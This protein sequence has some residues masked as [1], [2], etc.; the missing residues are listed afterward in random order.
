[1]SHLGGSMSSNSRNSRSS[2]LFTC[3]SGAAVLALRTD[4]Q[5]TPSGQELRGENQ[6]S[7]EA[8]PFTEY[9][10][11]GP[12]LKLK[13]QYFVH[14]MRWANSLEKTLMLGRIEGSRGR[15][16][17]RMRW[18]DGIVDSVGMSL[19][20]LRETVKARGSWRA[21]VRGVRKSQTQASNWTTEMQNL[22]PYPGRSASESA[23]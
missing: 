17:Q 10:L 16:W 14:L 5:S 18:P 6:I 15:G 9:S 2:S 4:T 19:S 11:E 3:F 21:A 20:K 8:S 12:M 23:C 7:S 13:L 1:M 22:G